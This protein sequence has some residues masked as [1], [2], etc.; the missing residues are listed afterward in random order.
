MPRSFPPPWVLL[1]RKPC[2]AAQFRLIRN[3]TQAR[4]PPHKLIWFSR[5]RRSADISLRFRRCVTTHH[6]N[7]KSPSLYVI[8]K[9]GCRQFEFRGRTINRARL[10]FYPPTAA[11][12]EIGSEA[13]Q[14]RRSVVRVRKQWRH[15]FHRGGKG[16]ISSVCGRI[17]N[18]RERPSDLQVQRSGHANDYEKPLPTNEVCSSRPPSAY[19]RQ[20]TQKQING[21]PKN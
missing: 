21:E 4:S 8:G 14:P 6:P 1:R 16:E 13:T 10:F 17:S 9:T 5:A 2:V 19:G 12:P 7:F 18:L 20:P 11:G 3:G 15:E